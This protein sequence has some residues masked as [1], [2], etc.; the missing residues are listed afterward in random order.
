MDK[1]MSVDDFGVR[2][3]VREVESAA[4][5]RAFVAKR[6]VSTGKGS[7][8][9]MNDTLWKLPTFFPTKLSPTP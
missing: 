6:R 4:R 5:T 7:Y 3:C 2:I 1:R 8:M 9:D